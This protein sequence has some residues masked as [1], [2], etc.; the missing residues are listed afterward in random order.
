MP[1]T[2]TCPSCGAGQSIPDNSTDV[3]CSFCGTRFSAGNAQ[4]FPQPELASSTDPYTVGSFDEE[5]GLEEQTRQ[6]SDPEP[7]AVPARADYYPAEK[8]EVLPPSSPRV[9][10]RKTSPAAWIAIAVLI[11]L[12]LCLICSCLALVI[13][14]VINTGQ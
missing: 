8:I 2:I 6:T 1:T 9:S 14:Q 4:V 7:Q 3:T 12:S 11:L 13:S 5:P 10:P